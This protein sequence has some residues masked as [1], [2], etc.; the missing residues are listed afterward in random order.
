MKKVIAALILITL[1]G[2]ATS[3]VSL[4]K[5]KPVPSDR[6]YSFKNSTSGS[7]T[8]TVIRDSGMLGGGC[9]YG[10]YV[11]G[12]KAALLNPAEK[13]D[14]H[15]KPGEWNIG[16][17]GEGKMCISDNFLSE[18]EVKLSGGQHKVVRLF[19]DPSGNLDV[20]P[21]SQ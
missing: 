18:R 21:V 4:N 2:C 7:S 16:F 20:K 13:V 10:L 19:A 12:E 9:Y 8:L 14:L 1:T 3:A 15:L 6:I 11:N 5:A 17:K